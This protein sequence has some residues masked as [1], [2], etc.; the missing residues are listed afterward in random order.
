MFCIEKTDSDRNGYISFYKFF[1]AFDTRPDSVSLH[2]EIMLQSDSAV[3]LCN[4]NRKGL[5]DSKEISAAD[6]KS[7]T[8]FNVSIPYKEGMNYTGI[9]FY[10]LGMCS[11]DRVFLRNFGM[12]ADGVNIDDYIGK[13]PSAEDHEFYVS[14]MFRFDNTALTDE[15]TERLETICLVWGFSKYYNDRIR[16]GERDWNYDL[17]RILNRTYNQKDRTS[18]NR[19]LAECI[20]S[21]KA[22]GKDKYSRPDNN[23]SIISQ[24]SFDWMARERLGRSL[25][26][27]LKQMREEQHGSAL[28]SVSYQNSNDEIIQERVVL[29]KNESAYPD[30][31][32]NDDGHRMLTLF[33]FWNMMYYFHPYIGH[34]EKRWRELLPEFIRIFAKARD[35]KSFDTACARLVFA[36]K[37][38]HTLPYGLETNIDGELLW[39]NNNYLPVEAVMADSCRIL[40]TRINAENY[41]NDGILPGDYITGVNG[42]SVYDI[43]KDADKYNHFASLSADQYAPAYIS[44][45]GKSVTYTVERDGDIRDIRINDF[46]DYWERYRAMED[47]TPSTYTCGDGMVY[48]N[49]GTINADS[50][51]KVLNNNIASK[52]IIFDMRGI[53]SIFRLF[54][55]HLPVFFIQSRGG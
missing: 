25:F 41:P 13:K 48:V 4:V 3:F 7:W 35:R 18:F 6:N 37:D 14:S 49:L 21:S 39:K 20:P 50:L 44:F 15:Q 42:R 28:M 33:R 27:K 55:I 2:G 10:I 47:N 5:M 9:Q 17:F 43:R 30:I 23:D 11:G 53:L 16:Q 24:L 26:K 12:D 46:M 36:M 38:S 19:A 54:S 52:A 45:P 40:I 34:F 8:K 51:A 29:F 32:P 22:S 1:D 31:S